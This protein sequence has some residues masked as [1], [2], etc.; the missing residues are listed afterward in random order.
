LAPSTAALAGAADRTGASDGLSGAL[1]VAGGG[2]WP[3]AGAPQV[4]AAFSP[5]PQPGRA[6][7]RGVDLLAAPG[8]RVQAPVAGVVAFAAVVVDRPVLVIV[9]GDLRVSLEPVTA[10][11]ATGTMVRQGQPIGVVTQAPSHCPPRTCLHWG[12][13]A[14]EQY[15]DPLLLTKPYRAVLL[16]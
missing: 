7:H 15:H 3:L 14:G 12:L 16:P 2:Q 1:P 9:N 4:V 11:V 8:A 6:G 10:L 13:R 5:P